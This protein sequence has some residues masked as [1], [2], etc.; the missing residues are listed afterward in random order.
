MTWAQHIRQPSRYAA[1]INHLCYKL[2]TA[3]KFIEVIHDK[4]AS[5]L[6]DKYIV[7]KFQKL[8]YTIKLAFLKAKELEQNVQND[9]DDAEVIPKRASNRKS[10]QESLPHS[11]VTGNTRPEVKGLKASPP[12]EKVPLAHPDASNPKAAANTGSNG[13]KDYS[14]LFKYS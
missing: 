7:K 2:E 3:E 12:G 10:F 5:C 6:K 13:A 4:Y 1:D 9:D 8:Q 11:K 14:F